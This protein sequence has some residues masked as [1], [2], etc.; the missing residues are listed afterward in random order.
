[1]VGDFLRLS[2]FAFGTIRALTDTRQED[3]ATSRLIV[4]ESHISS[5]SLEILRIFASNT[6]DQESKRIEEGMTGCVYYFVYCFS[7]IYE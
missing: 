1:M 6:L 2:S 4:A 3:T 5:R 7:G